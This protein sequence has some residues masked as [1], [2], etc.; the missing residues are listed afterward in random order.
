MTTA[1]FTDRTPELAEAFVELTGIMAA[2]YDIVDLLD[3]LLEHCVRLLDVDEAAL[4]LADGADA[5]KVAAST[6]EQTR[7]LELFQL[8]IDSGPCLDCFHSGESVTV[9]DL[10]THSHRWPEFSDYARRQGYRSV[11][12]T[13]LKVPGQTIGALNLFANRPSALHPTAV[14]IAQAFADVGAVAVVYRRAL[15]RSEQVSE[16]L[17][18]ALDSRVVIEQAK[19][20]LA[21]QGSLD[22]GAAFA[23]LRQ[24]TRS[25]NQKLSATA[26]A[27]VE[28]TL[29]LDQMRE[30]S[31]RT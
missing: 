31:T 16:Q 12:A 30:P 4:V 15:L 25:N 9:P 8:Q 7:F 28:G 1:R 22:M 6:S 10:D 29:A 18:G 24:Y 20:K 5:I 19:G 13:P 3:C 21:Q 14:K 27:V 11:H 17:R 23:I 26:R 2:G